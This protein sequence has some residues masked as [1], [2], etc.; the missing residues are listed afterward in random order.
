[1]A[2]RGG[3]PGWGLAVLLLSLALAMAFAVGAR[4]RSLAEVGPAEPVG[5]AGAVVPG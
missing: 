4:R 2:A 1:M 3:C 5:V